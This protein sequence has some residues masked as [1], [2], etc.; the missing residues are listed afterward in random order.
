MDAGADLPVGRVPLRPAPLRARPALSGGEHIPVEDRTRDRRSATLESM[1]HPRENKTRCSFV[2]YSSPRWRVERPAPRVPAPVLSLPHGGLF[3]FERSNY[4]RRGVCPLSA[5]TTATMASVLLVGSLSLTWGQASG[6][7]SG[8]ELAG[9]I[10]RVQTTDGSGPETR[11]CAMMGPASPLLLV[12]LPT[13]RASERSGDL[14]T[15]ANL[16]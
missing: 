11:R 8:S 12:P 14:S 16:A 9:T 3:G 1:C 2:V 10:D 4:G 15:S 5:T 7:A 13:R 6:S